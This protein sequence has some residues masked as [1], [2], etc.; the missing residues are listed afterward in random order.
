MRVLE[1]ALYVDDVDAV[2]AFY[3]EV[4]GFRVMDSSP[5]LVA[6]DAGHATVLL[7][8]KRGATTDGLRLP[9]G[10]IPPHDGGGPVHLAFAIDAGELSAW[11]LRLAEHGVAVESRVRWEGGGNSLYFRDPAGHSVELVT[12]G[13]WP[14]Y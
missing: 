4:L 8:F 3:R 7:V 9:G 2:A 11:E 6:L 5:R 14:V 13:T 12:P 10:W 1:T